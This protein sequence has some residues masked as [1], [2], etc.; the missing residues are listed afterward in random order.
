MAMAFWARVCYLR[1]HLPQGKLIKRSLISTYQIFLKFL[2]P[3][4]NIAL[5][6]SIY[7]TVGIAY[8]RQESMHS[9]N[10]STFYLREGIQK[11]RFFLGNSPKLGVGRGQES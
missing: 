5:S 4:N 7:T 9:Q 10:F 11:K 6:C 8:E 1:V 3:L 2:F